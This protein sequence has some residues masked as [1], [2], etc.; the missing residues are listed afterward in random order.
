MDISPFDTSFKRI[1]PLPLLKIKTRSSVNGISFS[2]YGGSS[3]IL[4]LDLDQVGWKVG[5]DLPKPLYGGASV[6][7][8]DSFLLVGGF[9][10]AARVASTSLFTFEVETG[11]WRELPQKLTMGHD[12]YL[13]A[14]L[15]SDD[16]VQCL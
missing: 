1:S 9:S 2:P 5:P 8:E 15:V 10:T 4:D 14:V 12:L 6:Q 11:L 3:E 7:Y 13:T 16:F